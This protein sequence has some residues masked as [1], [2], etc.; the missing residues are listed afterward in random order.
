MQ[1]KVTGMGNNS[2]CKIVLEFKYLQQTTELDCSADLDRESGLSEGKR[3]KEQMFLLWS[4]LY[5]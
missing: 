5:K 2:V 4:I 3:R 1:K